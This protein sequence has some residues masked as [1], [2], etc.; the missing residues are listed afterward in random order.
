MSNIKSTLFEA[1][2]FAAI[3]AFL[4]LLFGFDFYGIAAALFGFFFGQLYARYI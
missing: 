3:L 1:I 2:S 4:H